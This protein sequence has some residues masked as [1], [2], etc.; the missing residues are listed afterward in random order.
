[1]Y[2]LN[3]LKTKLHYITLPNTKYERK[4]SSVILVYSKHSFFLCLTS[5]GKHKTKLKNKKYEIPTPILCLSKILDK[6]EVYIIPWI[7][8]PCIYH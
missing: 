5:N 7:S 2:R 8:S 6:T 3:L 1:M 4:F